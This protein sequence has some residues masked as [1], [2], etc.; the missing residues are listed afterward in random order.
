MFYIVFSHIYLMRVYSILSLIL[1]FDFVQY[2]KN[3][4]VKT[5]YNSFTT[6]Q[7]CYVRVRYL[8]IRLAAYWQSPLHPCTLG[9]T[10]LKDEKYIKRLFFLK[11]LR[12]CFQWFTESNMKRICCELGRSE[13]DK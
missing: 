10:S 12:E 5:L 9:G 3:I 7:I 4:C 6:C 1:G 8:H 13:F 2:A 11:R